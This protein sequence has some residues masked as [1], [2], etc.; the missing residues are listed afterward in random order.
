MVKKNVVLQLILYSM[1]HVWYNGNL[2]K[3]QQPAKWGKLDSN[4]AGTLKVI[5]ILSNMH[6]CLYITP[7][8]WKM[9]IHAM[10]RH[11]NISHFSKLNCCFLYIYI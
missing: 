6:L 7:K 4:I 1:E 10:I 5:F 8:T 2:N 3:P 11:R 9:F